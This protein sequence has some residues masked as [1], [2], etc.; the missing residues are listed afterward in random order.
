V[1]GREGVVELPE[2]GLTEDELAHL[3][4]SAAGVAETMAA[5]GQDA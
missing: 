2:Y 4:A 1:L 5:F 3:R